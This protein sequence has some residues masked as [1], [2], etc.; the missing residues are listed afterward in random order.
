MPSS[1]SPAFLSLSPI[2]MKSG[3]QEPVDHVAQRD[4]FRIVAKAEIAPHFAS[5]R[6]LEPLAD[7]TADRARHGRRVHDD[8][9]IT[10]FAGE[11]SPDI[12]HD[13]QHVI[14]AE[15]A[16][17][18]TRRRHDDG[19]HLGPA[20]RLRPVSGRRNARLVLGQKLLQAGFLDRRDVIVDLFD[21]DRVGVDADDVIALGR[22]HGHNRSSELAQD[23]QPKPS[24]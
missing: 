20:D 21:K 3:M 10:R 5:G 11:R 13:R 4:E 24:C 12:V 6:M 16:V 18:A 7:G 2:R 19:G 8:E 15:R 17:G 9:V 22:E 14:V 1:R 23:R